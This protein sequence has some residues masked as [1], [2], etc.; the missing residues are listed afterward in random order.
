MRTEKTFGIAMGEP[1]S[2]PVGR[3]ARQALTKLGVWTT[4]EKRIVAADNVRT[5]L[6][7][8]ARGEAPLGIVYATDARI[9]SKVRVV[10]TFPS[11]S[12]DPIRYPA[13]ALAGAR[14]DGARFV[15][16]LTSAKARAIFTAAGFAP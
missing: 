13:A 5:A 11:D 12:H 1:T 8:V 3:Y 2:V 10:D 6:N 7:F 14:Q 15:R 4:V 9:E 16:F